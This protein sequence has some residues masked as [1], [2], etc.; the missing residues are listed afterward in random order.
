MN[1]KTKEL[2]KELTFYPAYAYRREPTHN[3]IIKKMKSH[4]YEK[5]E[6]KARSLLCDDDSAC[7]FVKIN[8]EW[9]IAY[10][11]TKEGD[12]KLHKEF[13]TKEHRL[14]DILKEHEEIDDLE[15]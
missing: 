5:A 10:S 7:V 14:S 3:D 4:S 15:R 12:L 1:K 11:R 13:H 9:Y 2:E 6:K 8:R